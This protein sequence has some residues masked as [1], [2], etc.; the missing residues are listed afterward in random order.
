ML[1]KFSSIISSN[2]FSIPFFFSSSSGTPIIQMLLHLMLSQRSLRQSAILFMLLFL[3]CSATVISNI[4]FSRS[5][6]HSSASVI[7]LLVPSTVFLISFIVL[8]YIVC[9]LFS[10]FRSLLNVSCIFSIPFLRF[11]IIF[12][13]ITLNSFSGR[14]PISSLLFGLVGFY[15]APSSAAYF[16]VFPFFLTYCVW[17]LLFACCR[18]IDPLTSSVCPQ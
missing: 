18:F 9:L 6:F 14:L 3:S 16:S 17:G 13:I 12:T 7:L 8:F 4:L 11:E 5:L 1:G 10:S 15:L 2:I